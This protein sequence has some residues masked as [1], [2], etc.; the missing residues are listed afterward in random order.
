ML[1]ACP[2]TKKNF[3]VVLHFWRWKHWKKVK[4]K[5]RGASFSLSPHRHSCLSLL[6]LLHLLTKT[7]TVPEM[8]PPSYHYVARVF[9]RCNSQQAT[10]R[11]RRGS[12]SVR[13]E[14]R[15]PGN[16]TATPSIHITLIHLIPERNECC[17]ITGTEK[18]CSVFWIWWKL[19][20][21]WFNEREAYKNVYKNT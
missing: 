16:V 14:G 15:D 10:Q 12:S 18:G 9:C 5:T 2:R 7:L 11:E 21:Q 20:S 6:L 3:F 13:R 4:W 17:C 8:S 19:R 1:K